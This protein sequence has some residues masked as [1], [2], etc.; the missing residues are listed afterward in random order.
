V[1]QK[2]GHVVRQIVGYHRY[3]TPAELE[4]LNQI[5]ALQRANTNHS[6]PQQKLVS[7]T[8][9]GAKITKRYDAARTPFQRVPADPKSV[10]SPSR[11]DFSVRTSR[12]TRAATQT[13]D[14]GR[15]PGSC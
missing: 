15:P 9:T 6:A 14:T 11:P 12:W 8:R 10:R 2:S 4:L 7:K 3:D 1:E 13:A 5:W